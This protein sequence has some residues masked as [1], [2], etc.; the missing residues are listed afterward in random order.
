MNWFDELKAQVETFLP[1]IPTPIAENAILTATGNFFRETHLLKDDAYISADCG[2]SDFVLD[3]PAG[4]TILQA[5][6]LRSTNAPDKYPLVSEAWQ[7]IPP[8][9]S[10]FGVGYWLDLQGEQ[11]TVS[12]SDC[13]RQKSGKYCLLYSWIPSNRECSIAQHFIGKYKQAI[14]YGA[15]SELYLVPMPEDINPRMSQYYKNLFVQQIR[16]ATAEEVQNHTDRPLY[17]RGQ[18]FI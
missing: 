2:V 7:I 1:N 11:P 12:I 6:G 5:K 16:N 10:R 4:R 3:I 18:C 8:A 13:Y 9:E 17:M 15:L 14:L